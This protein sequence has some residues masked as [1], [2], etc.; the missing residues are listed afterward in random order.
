MVSPAIKRQMCTYLVDTYQQ[1]I[2]RVCMV[3][4][5]CRSMWYYQSIRDDEP[6]IAKLAEMAELLPN[7]GFDTYYG[8][9]RRQGY[10][11]SRNKLL[12]VYRLMNLK[13]RR[14]Y[15]RRLPSRYKESLKVPS[16]PNHTWSM[17]FMSDALQDGR[18]IRVLNITDDFNREA[19]TIE[20]GLSFPSDRVIRTL[21]VMEE[22]YGLPQQIRVDN[23][24][25]FISS[26][27]QKWCEKNGIKLKFIQPG[28]PAQNAY[29][30]RFNRIF[31][32]DVLNA[33]W[34]E[35]LDQVRLLAEQWRM[36]YNQNHPHSSL[37]GFSPID[38]YRKAVNSGKAQPRKPNVTLPQLTAIT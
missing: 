3:L 28:R 12:R 1:S 23:G 16:E 33:Y 15:K 27:M 18:K 21:Q 34:F 6:V 35:S 5:F 24:P 17:D 11:W 29:I 26:R 7:R 9:L 14:K 10:K 30:E 2:R 38:H 25:E 13:L 22:E 19:L 8:R 32:E 4:S 20:V 31:R 37:N 36:D